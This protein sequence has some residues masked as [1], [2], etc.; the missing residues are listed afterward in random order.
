MRK[1]MQKE[2]HKYQ[3][4][5]YYFDTESK[6]LCKADWIQSTADYDHYSFELHHF[7]PFT[8]WEKNTKNVRSKVSNKLILLPKVMHQ[9]LENPIYKLSQSDFECVYGIH[10][11]K[12]LYDINSNAD[13][14]YNSPSLSH[15]I[16]SEATSNASE[17]SLLSDEDLS[18]F[19]D[20]KEVSYAEI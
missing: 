12:I 7:V 17:I 16:P 13:R 5:I 11:N 4:F 6:T 3:G 20:I 1:D 14:L 19:D 9:H 18:C 10:P 2:I 8:D 15:S